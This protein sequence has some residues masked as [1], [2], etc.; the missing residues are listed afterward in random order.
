MENASIKIKDSFIKAYMEEVIVS[1]VTL[2]NGKKYTVKIEVDK[3]HLVVETLRE[4]NK[5]KLT[6]EERIAIIEVVLR[7][8]ATFI[9]SILNA[10]I[11]LYIQ[12][13]KLIDNTTEE[14]INTDKNIIQEFVQSEYADKT[15]NEALKA[16][17]NMYKQLV[18]NEEKIGKEEVEIKVPKI[19]FI[20]EIDAKHFFMYTLEKYKDVIDLD[21]KKKKENNI[22]VLKPKK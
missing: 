18:E 17:R 11:A 6:E 4:L 10:S 13:Y 22:I 12:E 5:E 8:C 14:I 9:N 3:K 19:F 1:E 21:Y 15:T 20:Y 16:L 7:K 2:Q